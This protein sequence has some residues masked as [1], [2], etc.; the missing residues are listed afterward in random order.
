MKILLPIVHFRFRYS[1]LVLLAQLLFFFCLLTLK[2]NVFL[3]CSK[4]LEYNKTSFF[5]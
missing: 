4:V 1:S 2:G 5:A 3:V